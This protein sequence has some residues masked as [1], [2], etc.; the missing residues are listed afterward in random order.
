MTNHIAHDNG[1]MGVRGVADTGGNFTRE[2]IVMKCGFSAL[3]VTTQIASRDLQ[4]KWIWD[5]L[6]SFDA[7]LMNI[8]ICDI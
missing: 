4:S 1:G 3:L 8:N 2:A 5:L 7:L 6:I